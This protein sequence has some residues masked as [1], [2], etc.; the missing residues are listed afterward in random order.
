[1]N[2]DLAAHWKTATAQLQQKREQYHATVAL[3]PDAAALLSRWCRVALVTGAHT[4]AFPDAWTVFQIS[5][6]SS[7][8]ARFV[9]MGF[10]SRAQVL[11]PDSLRDEVLKELEEL[12]IMR[13]RKVPHAS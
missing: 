12:R 10:G 5:F 9:V 3:A 2:F 8:E 6:E 4:G 11:A 7:A 13:S 1:M